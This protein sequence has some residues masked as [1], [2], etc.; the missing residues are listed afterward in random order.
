MQKYRPLI[1]PIFILLAVFFIVLGAL[2]GDSETTLMK[3]AKICFE[4]IG[5]G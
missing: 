5:L 2:A 3:A 1:A 4:C